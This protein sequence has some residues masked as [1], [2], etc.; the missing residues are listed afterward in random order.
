MKISMACDHGGL[1]LKL[2]IKAHLEA[3]G[4]TVCD[5]GTD[6]LASCDYPTMQSL[7]PELWQAENVIVVF[8][9]A[10]PVSVFPSWQ[11]RSRV[12]A[13]LC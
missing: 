1:E 5:Y 6:S 12:S 7:R 4:F 8:W 13:V 2:A 3:R 11:T 9:S 10:P